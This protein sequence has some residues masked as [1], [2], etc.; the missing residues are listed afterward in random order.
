MHQERQDDSYI[1]AS[2]ESHAIR[3]YYRSER[4]RLEIGS[5]LLYNTDVCTRSGSVERTM[6]SQKA[7]DLYV[8]QW[9]DVGVC[10]FLIKKR[11]FTREEKGEA[12]P[13]RTFRHQTTRA[14]YPFATAFAT[15]FTGIM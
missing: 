9:A 4:Q 3:Y 1:D 5:I 14:T 10:F 12:A 6:L 2:L 7:C 13:I 11:N 8:L 15:A